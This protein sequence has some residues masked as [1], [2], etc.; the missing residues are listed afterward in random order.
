MNTNSYSET[1]ECS[2]CDSLDLQDVFFDS[3][4][5]DYIEFNSWFAQKC[6]AE[7]RKCFIIRDNYSKIVGLCIYKQESP[8]YEMNGLIIKMCTFKSSFKGYKHGELLLRRMLERCYELNADWLYV[9]AYQSNKVCSFFEKFGFDRYKERKKDT[10]E[11]IYRKKL[12]PTH[13]DSIL[14]SLD[15]HRKYGYRFFDRSEQ[16]FLVP[17]KENLYDYLF[18]EASSKNEDVLRLLNTESNAIRKKFR[19]KEHTNLI[20]EGSI[21]LFCKYQPSKV[22]KCCGI[23][24]KVFRSKK[25]EVIKKFRGDE[26]STLQSHKTDSIEWLCIQFRHAENLSKDFYLDDLMKNHL[27]KGYPRVITKIS[28]EVKNCILKNMPY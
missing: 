6:L 5:K 28:D 1:I 7:H 12:K 19:K 15:Y 17:L 13:E 24:E 10:G 26:L 8:L 3:L 23:V 2:T 27:I 9:T 11:L 25:H 22:I 4:R 21:L 20:K 16:A 18:P 14:S